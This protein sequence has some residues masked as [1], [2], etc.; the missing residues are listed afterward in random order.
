LSNY[1]VKV[2]FSYDMSVCAASP[3]GARE[4]A[5][6]LMSAVNS[7]HPDFELF[8]VLSPMEV[9]KCKSS[10]TGSKRSAKKRRRT[11]AKTAR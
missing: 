4:V 2:L 5:S 11:C 10:Q 6:R 8:M 3:D 7:K 9:P 1:R